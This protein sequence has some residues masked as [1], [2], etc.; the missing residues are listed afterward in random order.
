MNVLFIKHDTAIDLQTTLHLP[1]IQKIRSKEIFLLLLLSC[2]HG[3]C[4]LEF[5][6]N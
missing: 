6:R 2:V 3:I 4:V 1:K 5:Y